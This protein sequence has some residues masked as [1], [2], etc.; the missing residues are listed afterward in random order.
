[1]KILCM[2]DTH[3]KLMGCPSDWPEADVVVHAGDLTMMGTGSEIA[4]AGR[5]L[6]TLPAPEIVVI[7]GNH[8]WGFQ[9]DREV[10][11]AILKEHCPHV[12]Y[13]QDSGCEIAG[14]KFW[15]SPWQPWFHS[16]AFNLERGKALREK[17]DLIPDGTDVLITH[18]PPHGIL[19]EIAWE[20]APAE[21]VGCEELNKRVQKLS[22]P[23]GRVHVFGHIHCAYGQDILYRTHFIN[24]AICNEQYE[25]VN[26]PVLIEL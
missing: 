19:D 7:A 24:A 1:M 21:H 14:V 6:N 17:W 23:E 15:G 18:G 3:N 8:D 9:R 11:E 16:W 22:R 20:G 26:E 2:S 10:N 5:W 12:T 4:A 25:P 13:L